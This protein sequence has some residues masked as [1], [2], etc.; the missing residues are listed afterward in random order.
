VWPDDTIPE[1]EP[2]FK[3]LGRLM[4]DVGA[5][6]SYHIDLYVASKIRT[7]KVGTLYR[8]IREGD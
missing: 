6:L 5:M 1:L 3:S 7:Y 4:V 8:Y 2:A